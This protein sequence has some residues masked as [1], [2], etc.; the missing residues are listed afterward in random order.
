[1]RALLDILAR[2]SESYAPVI[3]EIKL[4][5]AKLVQFMLIL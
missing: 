4:S 1:M 2:A 3:R 5:M